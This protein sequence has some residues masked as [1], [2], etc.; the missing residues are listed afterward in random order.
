MCRNKML[1]SR[2]GRSLEAASGSHVG[3]LYVQERWPVL[4]SSSS[5]CSVQYLTCHK[6]HITIPSKSLHWLLD[7]FQT[8]TNSL[9]MDAKP[10]MASNLL[11]FQTACPTALTSLPQLLHPQAPTTLVFT[12]RSLPFLP[13]CP[14]YLKPPSQTPVQCSFTHN[15]K[16]PH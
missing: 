8:S 2:A 9:P 13:C 15:L 10:A 14:S 3:K 4:V 11:S 6:E 7:H 12:Q 5:N 16:I 1:S